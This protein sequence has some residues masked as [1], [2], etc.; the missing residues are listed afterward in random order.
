MTTPE[1][2]RHEDPQHS[3]STITCEECGNVES[4]SDME[5]CPDCCT[6]I[7]EYRCHRPRLKGM[8]CHLKHLQAEHG[9]TEEEEAT[10]AAVQLLR[11]I[12][13]YNS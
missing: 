5:R 3:R 13:R 4:I 2:A 11:Q 12:Q 6:M 7:P 1:D 10:P 8:G 9:E